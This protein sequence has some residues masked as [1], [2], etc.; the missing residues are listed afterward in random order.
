MSVSSFYFI[1]AKIMKYKSISINLVCCIDCVKIII[2]E[3]SP[4]DTSLYQTEDHS[5][6]VVLQTLTFT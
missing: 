5:I 1:Y 2:N 4:G 3:D 6:R